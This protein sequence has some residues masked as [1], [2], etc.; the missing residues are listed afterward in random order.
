MKIS[1][2]WMTPAS[3]NATKKLSHQVQ[4]ASVAAAKAPRLNLGVLGIS[5]GQQQSTGLTS[6]V[7]VSEQ[8]NQIR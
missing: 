6:H 2:L 1:D 3:K 4:K 8:K 7:D 5:I